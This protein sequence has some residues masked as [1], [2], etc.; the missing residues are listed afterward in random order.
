MQLR[1]DALRLA[2]QR[3]VSGQAEK[4]VHRFMPTRSKLLAPKSKPVQQEQ[5]DMN[6]V[7][8]ARRSGVQQ[9][10]SVVAE[11]LS[12]SRPASIPTA[13]H[14]DGQQATRCHMSMLFSR[15]HF[16]AVSVTFN[17]VS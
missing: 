13:Q 8:Q 12:H 1:S 10:T 3:L 17:C 11:Q 6:L 14:S 7:T 16:V 2:A 15:A 5:Q 4:A 9:Q